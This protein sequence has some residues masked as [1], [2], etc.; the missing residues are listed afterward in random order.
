MSP[1][2][3]VNSF[4]NDYKYQ[5]KFFNEII[6]SEKNDFQSTIIVACT[7]SVSKF[8]AGHLCFVRQIITGNISK[9]NVHG[10]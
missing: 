8:W 9:I 2:W 5:S 10:I 7:I 4:V 3:H 6:N 1:T